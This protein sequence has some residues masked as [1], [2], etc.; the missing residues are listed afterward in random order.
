VGGIEFYLRRE[1]KDILAYL[2]IVDN[3][4]D[5]ESL[6]R[7]LGVPGRGAG[8]RSFE[9]VVAAA[10]QA[11]QPLIEYLLAGAPDADLPPRASRGLAAFAADYREIAAHRGGGVAEILEAVLRTIDYEEFLRTE[12][13]GEEAEERLL[14][15]AELVNTAREYDDSEAAGSLTGFLERVNLLADVDRWEGQDRVSLLTL[16]SAKGLEFSAVFIAGVE[17]GILPLARDPETD[18]EEEERRLL[19]VGITRARQRLTLTHT[20]NR[21]RFG[22]SRRAYPSRFLKEIESRLEAPQAALEIDAG[23]AGGPAKREDAPG[24][25]HIEFEEHDSGDSG[26]GEWDLDEDPYPV[27]TRVAH[28]TYGEGEVVRVSGIGARRRI[29]VSF[30]D[31]EEKQFV[32]GYSSLRRLG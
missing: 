12:Y 2:R 14:N 29:T 23:A 15:V 30:A 25:R 6:K 21:L 1:V 22:R 28:E 26:Y 8:K 20:T 9:K 18:D 13:G 16:H 4:R 5:S 17:D 27:G 10:R 31:G 3:P 11:R 7:A 19:Y 32:L 24:E